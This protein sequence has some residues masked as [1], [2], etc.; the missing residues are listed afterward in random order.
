MQSFLRHLRGP[1]PTEMTNQHPVNCDVDYAKLANILASN[2]WDVTKLEKIRDLFLKGHSR[3]QRKAQCLA[4]N[5]KRRCRLKQ[6]WIY[7]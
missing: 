1:K 4:S 5:T 7:L 2:N 6:L 3:V